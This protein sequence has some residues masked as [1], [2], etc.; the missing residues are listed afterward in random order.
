[1]GK[2]VVN[3][4]LL[5]KVLGL[6]GSPN[7]AE[8]LAAARRADAMVRGTGWAAL[9]QRSSVTGAS[10]AVDVAPTDVPLKKQIAEAFKELGEKAVKSDQKMVDLLAKFRRDG[11]L[12]QAERKPLFDAVKRRRAA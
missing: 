5:T 12:S 2:P 11:Y 1:M 9:L 8:A 3:V 6:L 7:D 4:A 10:D